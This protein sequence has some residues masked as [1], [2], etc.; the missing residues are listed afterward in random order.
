MNNFDY[1]CK[2]GLYC[3]L[4]PNITVYP[5]LATKLKDALE[6]G[7]WAQVGESAFTGFDKFWEILGKFADMDKNSPLCKGGCGNPDCD[8]RP[9]ATLKHIDLCAFCP[10]YPCAKIDA[11]GAAYPLIYKMNE[12]A[13]QLG[14]EAWLA[15]MEEF[16]A[17]GR[18]FDSVF[19][20]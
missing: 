16:A 15:K 11:L 6:A 9:C 7:G 2:C 18:T 17:Q 10:E 3:K 13:R 20:K 1:V 14:F 19:S 4:C 5:A 8:I 12:L